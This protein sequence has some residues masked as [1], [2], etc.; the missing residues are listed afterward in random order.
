MEKKREMARIPFLR[1]KTGKCRGVENASSAICEIAS[2]LGDET[3]YRKAL[4]ERN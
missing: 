4:S 2:F 1:K 3:L